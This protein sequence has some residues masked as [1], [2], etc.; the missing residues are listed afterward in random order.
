MEWL[1]VLLAGFGMGKVG[2]IV[3]VGVCPSWD[4]VCRFDGVDWGD[5][6]LVD[7]STCRPAG[8]ALN[9]SRVLAWVGRKNVAA[10]LWGRDDY[11]QLKA[12]MR[13]LRGG[14]KVKMTVVAGGTRRNVTVVDTD[15]DREMH[16]RFKCGLASA[17][18][19]RELGADLDGIVKKGDICVFAG[20]MPESEFLGGVVRIVEDCSSRGARIAVDTYGEALRRIVDTGAAW[21]INPNVAEL[22]ELL[23]EDVA[24]RPRSLVKAARGLLDKVEIILVSRGK[25]GA[26]VVT[27][28]GAWHGRCVGRGRVLSTVGCGDY[29]LGGFLKGLTEASN[30]GAALKTGLKVATAKAWGWTEVKTWAQAQRLIRIELLRMRP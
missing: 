18:A 11:E 20:L 23:G 19:L 15:R 28:D 4:L 29:L 6:R 12:A 27:P 25:N 16:L 30:P 10:G 22:R 3:S 1:F 13:E 8:K 14:V 24:D 2:K 17:R 7:S 26:V 5:H 21:L 9:I